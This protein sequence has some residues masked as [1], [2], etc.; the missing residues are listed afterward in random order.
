MVCDNISTGENGHL[1]FAGQDTVMLAERYGTPLYLIDE[2][3]LR[4]NCRVYSEAFRKHFGD[5]AKALY[6][7]KANSFKRIYE[8][9]R[10]ED[11]GIDVEIGRASCRERV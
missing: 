11:M 1:Y 5:K 2:D 3:R 9:M 8:I 7:G 6:A 10:E 4:H